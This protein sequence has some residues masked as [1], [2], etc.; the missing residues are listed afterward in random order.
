MEKKTVTAGTD[1]NR[2]ETTTYY[3]KDNKAL[4]EL[5]DFVNG[6]SGMI[7]PWMFRSYAR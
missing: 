4:I 5:G 7:I 3:V 6:K 2:S 1:N